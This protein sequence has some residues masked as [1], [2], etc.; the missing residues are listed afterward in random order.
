[1]ENSIEKKTIVYFKSLYNIQIYIYKIIFEFFFLK[2]VFNPIK[3]ILQKII[4]LI[5][6]GILIIAN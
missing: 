6:V 4:Y 5:Y 1:M 2:R 3:F